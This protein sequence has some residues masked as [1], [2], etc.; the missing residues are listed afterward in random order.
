MNNE[1]ENLLR[2]A[3][4]NFS[5]IQEDVFYDY[6]TMNCF[7]FFASLADS[8]PA[9][10]N[11]L[12]LNVQIFYGVGGIAFFIVILQALMTLFAIGDVGGEIPEEITPDG[13]FSQ[14]AGLGLIS[15]R[16]LTA[17]FMGFGLTG[18]ILLENGYAF[19]WAIVGAIL[20]GSGFMALIFWI[21][22][23]LFGLR[24]SGNINPANSKGETG[25]VYVALPP[26]RLAGGQVE[27]R[28]SGRIMTFPAI[29]ASSEKL[30]AGTLVR[31]LEVLPSN[32][33][34]VEKI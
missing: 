8:I 11:A 1:N 17:F 20:V 12:S 34:L 23:M 18:A 5:C 3:K 16:T 21:M 29:T 22:K 4:G 27:L 33:L 25:T 10:W 31:V 13:A 7:S 28:V 14:D 26:N 30:P 6:E 2:K 15:V 24:A 19:P 32:I 9:W